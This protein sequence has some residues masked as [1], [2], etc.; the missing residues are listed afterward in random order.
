MLVMV[1]CPYESI[2]YGV[3]T[4]SAAFVLALEGTTTE[5]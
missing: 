2:K 5:S 4:F 3:T 1:D